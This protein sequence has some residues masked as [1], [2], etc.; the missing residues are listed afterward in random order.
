M[1][2]GRRR[3]VEEE[4]EG[5]ERWLLTYADMITL[6]M[7][8][9]MVLFSISSVNKSKYVVLQK[10]LKDAFSGRV[11]PGGKGIAESAA[12]PASRVVSPPIPAAAPTGARIPKQSKAEESREFAQLKRRIDR[13]TAKAGLSGKVSTQ[14]TRDGLL[15]RLLTDKLL[16]DSGS[17]TPNPSSGPLLHEVGGAL[18]TD[19]AHPIQV[20]GFT[21]N[22]PIRSAAFPTN[23]ELSTARASAVVRT[24]I[25]GHVSASQLT[26]SGRGE[27]EPITDN[28]TPAGRAVNRRVEILLPRQA[29]DGSG[30]TKA[31]DRLVPTPATEGQ[32]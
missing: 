7:A 31:A 5:D 2:R 29:T 15:I 11:L 1:A 32:P 24:L 6:L 25:T 30:G 10:S 14:V 17:A 22:V 8:L 18:A 23:W 12:A 28:D 16:F 13:Y 21:D 9:F 3:R 20:M 26:A 27:L 19:R 4:S